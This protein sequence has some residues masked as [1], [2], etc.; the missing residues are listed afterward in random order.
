MSAE[1]KPGAVHALLTRSPSTV[2]MTR[3]ESRRRAALGALEYVFF[4]DVEATEGRAGRA[5]D[6]QAKRARAV[7]QVSLLSR[8][9]R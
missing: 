3:I 8:R 6:R 4:I 9:V 2:S 5:G 7:P 1:N